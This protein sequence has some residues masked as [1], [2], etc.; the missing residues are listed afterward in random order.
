VSA[1]KEMVMVVQAPTGEE[2]PVTEETRFSKYATP[3]SPYFPILL[4]WERW[5]IR[6]GIG[7]CVVRTAGNRYAVYR[8]GLVNEEQ[9]GA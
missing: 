3:D 1:T 8:N 2:I 7:A 4:R 9:A 6:R 5:F